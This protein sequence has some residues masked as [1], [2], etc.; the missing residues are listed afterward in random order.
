[1]SRASLQ[2]RSLSGLANMT[3]AAISMAMRESPLQA[4]PCGS[5][6]RLIVLCCLPAQMRD[7]AR[8]VAGSLRRSTAVLPAFPASRQQKLHTCYRWT[9]KRC[10]RW[11]SGTSHCNGQ[12]AQ[13]FS[14]PV[15]GEV[16]RATLGQFAGRCLVPREGDIDKLRSALEAFIT[17]FARPQSQTSMVNLSCC[18]RIQHW[19]ASST[20]PCSD[21]ISTLQTRC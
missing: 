2:A 13:K 15:T 14:D 16:D 9:A 8:S 17:L 18:R 3:T 20:R 1:M 4:E 21:P 11:S 7:V 19:C 5:R 6:S 12:H 10:A